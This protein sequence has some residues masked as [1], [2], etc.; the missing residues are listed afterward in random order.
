LFRHRTGHYLERSLRYCEANLE[1]F[2][3][4]EDNVEE[5]LELV[6]K[7]YHN[8]LSKDVPKERA[9]AVLPLGLYTEY[10]FQMDMRNLMHMLKMRLDESAQGETREY[11][12]AIL[13]HVQESFPTIG[14]Y[15][16]K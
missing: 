13:K 15:L 11:A 14:E 3:P 6:S 7:L 16:E 2:L 4:N 8:L 12:H 9:R 5:M 10:Y 1:M